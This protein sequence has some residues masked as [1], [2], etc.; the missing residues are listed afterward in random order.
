[1]YRERRGSLFRLSGLCPGYRR[2]V[3]ELSVGHG[4]Q[5]G[6]HIAQICPGIQATGATGFDDRVED[7]TALASICIADELPVLFADGTGTDHVFHR[8]VVDL[9]TA[10][11]YIHLQYGPERQGIIQ[12]TAKSTFRQVIAAEFDSAQSLA[13]TFYYGS[14]LGASRQLSQLS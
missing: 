4:R 8:V 2:D 12:G 10:I 13:Q 3:F 11:F 14:A 7:G 5:A 9:H 1:M 6:E